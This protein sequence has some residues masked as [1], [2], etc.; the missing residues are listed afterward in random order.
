M[1]Q[2]AH[3]FGSAR[4]L[5][6]RAALVVGASDNLGAAT[7]RALAALGGS[8]A[9]HYHSPESEA[10]AEAVAADVRDA[11]GDA[12]LVRADVTDA[13]ETAR[14]FDEA[15]AALGPLHAVV[16]TAGVM[17]KKPAADVDDDEYDRMFD[18]HAKG[19]F[20]VLQQAGRRV[21]DGGRIVTIS[22]TLT[23]V[24]APMYSVYAGAKAAAE[25]FANK[26]AKEVGA[27]GV[28]VNAVAP[29]PLD[30]SFFH[31]AETEESTE[32]LKHL[33]I[34]GELGR[35]DQVVPLLAFLTLPAAG[36]ITGQ[37]VRV[38]GGMA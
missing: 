21:A 34:S 16:N 10:P 32:F 9:V 18:V 17:L 5:D 6:G 26:L 31:P 37:T 33:S 14:L 13:A 23:S 36:W 35:V 28:T 20:H 7:A 29:G 2:T 25:Q 8:V 1:P 27:R 11:G 4:P 12:V 19:A 22:T 24:T 38:N 15:E 30:T 3:P